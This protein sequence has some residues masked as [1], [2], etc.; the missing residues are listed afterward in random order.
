[1]NK[2]GLSLIKKS[3]G[4]EFTKEGWYEEEIFWI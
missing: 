2:I 1:M 4:G 3:I